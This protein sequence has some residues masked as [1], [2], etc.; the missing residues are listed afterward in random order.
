M[1]DNVQ[2]FPP[3]CLPSQL[4]LTNVASCLMCIF[5]GRHLIHHKPIWVG[6]H[7]QIQNF[8]TL[9]CYSNNVCNTMSLIS[10]M[11]PWA[12]ETYSLCL[13]SAVF[14]PPLSAV[15]SLFWS[16]HSALCL[17]SAAKNAALW[18][19]LL[20]WLLLLLGVSIDTT[21]WLCGSVL[22]AWGQE[23][24]CKKIM[25]GFYVWWNMCTDI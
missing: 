3:K 21:D 24:A 4:V 11:L 6:S 1:Y 9:W 5:E 13:V 15:W 10:A 23:R 17:L 19:W 12:L 16:V 25:D 22:Y 7:K 18:C 14:G 2:Y 8:P 20:L